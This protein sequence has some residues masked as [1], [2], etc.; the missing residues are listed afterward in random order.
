HL[1]EAERRCFLAEARRVAP[2]LLVVDAALH[3]G[4]ER[5]EWQE[6]TLD[7]GSEWR[8]YKRFFTAEGLLAELGGGRTLHAG[9]WFVA[10]SS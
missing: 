1:E 10:V 7:D 4:P 6:R 9:R 5:E 2:E 3:G 8:V